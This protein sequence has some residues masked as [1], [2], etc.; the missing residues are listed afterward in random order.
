MKKIFVIHDSNINVYPQIMLFIFILIPQRKRYSLYLRKDI[1]LLIVHHFSYERF[2]SHIL[3][4]SPS[5][6]TLIRPPNGFWNV[7]LFRNGQS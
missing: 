6:V 1:H 7:I 4:L 5:F 3:K 2:F